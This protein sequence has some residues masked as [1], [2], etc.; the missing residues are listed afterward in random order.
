MLR[1][2]D[3]APPRPHE[4]FA[5][6][7]PLGLIGLAVGCAALVPIAF[8]RSLD[9][10]G[11]E[12]AA[13]FCLLFGAGCQL[14]AGLLSLA[15]HNLYGGTLFTA[16]AFNWVFNWW[17]LHGLARGFVPDHA[18]VLAVETCFLVVFLVITY[19]FGFYSKLLFAF[20]LDIDLLFVCK[21]VNG[22]AGTRAMDP[23]I[24]ILTVGLLVLSLWL[25]FALLVNPTAGRTLFPMPGPL[26]HA[27]ARPAFDPRPRRAI[28]GSLYG[29][30]KAHG[31][32][33]MPLGDLEQAVAGVVPP[34]ALRAELAYLEELGGV[35]LASRPD[36]STAV[37][38]AAPGIDFW[39]QA[40]LG[41]HQFV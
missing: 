3:L 37:T 9:P 28:L 14:V 16:F 24:A 33:P 35:R 18:V 36:G 31:D 20:L 29:H 15:N 12:T 8:G 30:W 11:L 5:E 1:R 13:M 32:R 19:G 25:A 7:S 22:F 21:V 23:L 26:F 34:P 4:R 17:A 2:I 39:E 10:A 40:T 27:P 6:P 41:K 38:L